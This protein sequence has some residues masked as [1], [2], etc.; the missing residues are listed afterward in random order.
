[1]RPL[2]IR[3]P[4]ILSEIRLP[5]SALEA[6]FEIRSLLQQEISKG[7]F[8]PRCDSWLA[9]FDPAF[10]RQ[11]G[12][13]GFIGMTWPKKYGGHAR[14]AIDRYVVTEE[15]LAHGAPVAAHWIADRQTGPLL[16]KYGTEEQRARY[17][18]G[19]ARGEIYFSLGLS[20]PDSGSDLASLRTKATKA[21]NG[22]RVSGSKI[23]TSHAHRS[24]F[25][26]TLVRTSAERTKHEGLSQLIVSLESPG[27][28]VRPIRLISGEEHFNEVFLDDVF[29]PEE[30]L[31]GREG[32]GWNQV[33]HELALERSG[34][35]R[36]LSTF[37]LLERHVQALKP[38][39]PEHARVS[40]GR[41]IASLATLR[42]MSLGTATIID[43]GEDPNLSSA[44]VKDL[45]TAFEKD[46]IDTSRGLAEPL[47][48]DD[49]VRELYIE[50]QLAAPG[51]TLRGGTSEILR[52]VIAKELGL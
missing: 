10:S 33:I 11:L 20:E 36:F 31:V 43:R 40:V 9:G 26:M 15:I 41:L 49:I 35:E 12:E 3:T 19:I 5:Q 42:A 16:L 18:P 28:T 21:P 50:A 51:F 7:T 44:I 22:W 8:H 38:D 24:P 23:W 30:C 13:Y 39:A 29:V 17:L 1:M 52:V 34:P 2:A 6:R 32:D 27:V 47:E 25:M 45:G 48:G 14:S 37:P 46:V 4:E